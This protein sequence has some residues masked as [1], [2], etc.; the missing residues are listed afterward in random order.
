MIAIERTDIGTH[1]EKSFNFKKE[2]DTNT[3]GFNV[4]AEKG[5]GGNE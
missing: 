1:K 2:N 3:G 5:I 4:C